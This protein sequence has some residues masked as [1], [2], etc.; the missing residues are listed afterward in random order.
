MQGKH[1]YEYAIIRVLPKVERE[2]FVNV[3]LILF[4]KKE[5]FI[6]LEYHI[7]EKR[8]FSFS[9][10]LDLE[11]IDATL[12]SY[13]LIAMGDPHASTIAAMEIPERFRWLTAV[14]SSCIQSSR[15]HSGFS[16]DLELTFDKLFEEL[17]L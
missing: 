10:E 13:R 12:K 9:K 7:D 15:P 16:D 3:G 14:R 11:S 1:L 4:S 5:K 8:L 2:E 6:K 17:I